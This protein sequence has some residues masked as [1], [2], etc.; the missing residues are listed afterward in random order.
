M[1]FNLAE[2]GSYGDAV[3]RGVAGGRWSVARGRSC[4]QV[5]AHI[6]AV[7]P[8]KAGSSTPRPIDLDR[9]ASGILDHSAFADDDSRGMTQ[10]H[11][12][13][14]RFARG[15]LSNFLPLQSEGVG[16]AG[17]TLHPRSR[18]QMCAKRR[19][20]AYRA[21]EASDI[22]CAMVLRLMSCFPRSGRARCHR[23]RRNCFPNLTPASGRQDHT[24]SPHAYITGN[25]WRILVGKNRSAVPNPKMYLV[26]D[27]GG[28]K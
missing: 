10:L 28:K 6:L 9:G 1:A 18:V 23:R 3:L 15:W 14:A 24:T 5:P 4:S 25:P 17:C 13:A 2:D 12:L 8:A 21:A 27:I 22:P 16:N 11:D 19:T 20:R 26:F 7:I